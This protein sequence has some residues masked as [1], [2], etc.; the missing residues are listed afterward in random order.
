MDPAITR[1]AEFESE[2]TLDQAAYVLAR[3]TDFVAR[4]VQQGRI[5]GRMDNARG[6]GANHRYLISRPALITYLIKA[7]TGD[8]SLLLTAIATHWPDLTDWS[9]ALAAG[10]NPAPTL[11]QRRPTPKLTS[12]WHPAQ[13]ALFKDDA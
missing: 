11:N 6:S 9:R 1:L 5:A 7:T 3:G 12:D 10:G 13:L 4:A 2:L 8:R